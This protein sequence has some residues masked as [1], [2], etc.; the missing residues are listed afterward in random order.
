MAE[1]IPVPDQCHAEPQPSEGSEKAN[2]SPL[3][4]KN[5]D[6]L[7][8]VCPERF[9]NS[10]LAPLLHCHRDQRAHDSESRDY[11]DKEQEKKHDCPL[12][13]HCLEILTV[14]VDPGLCVF[15]RL[16]KLF[17]R[18]FDAFGTVRIIGLDG[19]AV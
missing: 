5:P 9:H 13:P 17:N 1:F 16:K 15:R 8:D 11:Y 18:F 2:H 7:R 10:Y 14:H 4:E 19:D 6:D 3:A 12:E